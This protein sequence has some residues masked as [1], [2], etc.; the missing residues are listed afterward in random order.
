MPAN[1]NPNP[2]TFETNND[3]LGTNS[4]MQSVP[5]PSGNGITLNLNEFK[6]ESDMKQY[7]DRNPIEKLTDLTDLRD[8]MK[9]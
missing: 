5:A 1:N 4:G 9:K 3:L 8:F 6:T 7:D 2:Y